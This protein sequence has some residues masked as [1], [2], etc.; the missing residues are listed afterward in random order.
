MTYLNVIFNIGKHASRAIK[1]LRKSSMSCSYHMNVTECHVT[2]IA[3]RDHYSPQPAV[4]KVHLAE[5]QCN[6]QKKCKA[7]IKVSKAHSF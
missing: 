7:I 1:I 2:I 6:R 4:E 5:V 3:I